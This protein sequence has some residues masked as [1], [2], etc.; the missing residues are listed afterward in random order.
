MIVYT[1]FW[2]TL[3]ESSE[4]TYT[5]INKHHINS[6]TI[7]RLRNNQPITMRT[8]NDLCVILHCDVTDI[9]QFIPEES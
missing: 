9:I 1:P 2:K 7:T 4:T 5:L 8:L 6:T 3:K